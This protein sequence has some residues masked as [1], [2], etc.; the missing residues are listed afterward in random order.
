MSTPDSLDDRHAIDADDAAEAASTGAL[1]I[2]VRR[3]AVF[4]QADS[5]LPGAEWR[6]P[7][8]AADWAAAL[9]PRSQVVVYCVHGHEVSQGA[10]RQLREAGHDARYL[11]GGFEG[12][13]A[14]GRPVQPRAGG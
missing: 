7:A 14:A 11:R 2:D 4:A 12:W 1:L 6:D 10:A 3:A 13:R 9:P 5:L 8:C